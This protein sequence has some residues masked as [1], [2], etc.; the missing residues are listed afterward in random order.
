MYFLILWWMKTNFHMKGWAPGREAKS[1]VIR[2][3][4]IG[5]TCVKLALAFLLVTNNINHLIVIY[6]F[7]FA[8]LF[9]SGKDT[10]TAWANCCGPERSDH[11]TGNS[12]PY[13]LRIVCGFLINVPQIFTTRVAGRDLRLIV[14]MQDD[15]KVQPFANVITKA[16]L[17]TRLLFLTPREPRRCIVDITSW[18]RLWPDSAPDRSPAR[19]DL[20]RDNPMLNQLSHWNAVHHAPLERG[21]HEREDAHKCIL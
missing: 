17:S 20:P 2:K 7:S 8:R 4:L 9:F 3:W 1:S 5:V 11:N 16:A 12:V 19:V 15:L 6:L 21:D 14:L 18:V 13:S 10:A